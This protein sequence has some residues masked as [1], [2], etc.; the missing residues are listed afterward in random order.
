SSYFSILDL[1]ESLSC[2]LVSGTRFDGTGPLRKEVSNRRITQKGLSMDPP[3]GSSY[4]SILDL[5]E[6]LSCILVSST[7]F[8]G[9]GPLVGPPI[10]QPKYQFGFTYANS[11]QKTC[12]NTFKG[13]GI[14]RPPKN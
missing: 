7:R 1:L 8:D 14:R 4:F 12:W 10:L 2:I 3:K 6:S 5:L 13:L 9:T 11:S